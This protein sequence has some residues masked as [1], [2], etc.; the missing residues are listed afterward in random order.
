MRSLG[1]MSS[2]APELDDDTTTDLAH[3]LVGRLTRLRSLGATGESFP[4]ILD[5]PFE[6]LDRNVKPALLELLSR[7]AGAP[8]V[9][10]LTEDEDIASWARLEVLTGELSIVEP[11]PEADAETGRADQAAGLTA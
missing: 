8:Q 6:G 5:E 9:L 4:L 1:T 3:A 11:Q 2:T 7:A 10:V